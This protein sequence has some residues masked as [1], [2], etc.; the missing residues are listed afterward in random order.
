MN[1]VI[2]LLLIIAASFGSGA[3][4]LRLT[5]TYLSFSYLERLVISFI[6]GI[7]VIGWSVFYLALTGYLSPNN[8][9]V[10]LIGLS[11]GVIFLRSPPLT[12]LPFKAPDLV[13]MVLIG[14]IALIAAYD[15]FEGLAPPADGDSLAYHFAL[16]KLFLN[17]GELVPV[18][19]AV[20]GAIPLLQQ[21]T[22]LAALG[23]GGEQ[24][25]TLWVMVT[26]W[27]AAFTVY[28]VARRFVGNN[29]SLAI[30]LIFL[31]T[32]AVVYGAGSGQVEVRN[33]SFV[34]I[35]A[36]AIGLARK[37][38]LLRFALLAGLAAGF[39]VA[40]KYTGL[41][42]AASAGTLLLFKKDWFRHCIVFSAAVLVAGSQWYGW[43]TW[44]TGDPVFPLL[45]GRL[46]YLP[47][48]P[49]NELIHEIYNDG[50][51]EKSISTD[52]FWF[53]FYPFKATLYPDPSFESLRTGFGPLVLLVLPLS[54]YGLWHFRDRLQG[55]ILATIGAICLISY[56]VWFFLGPS[57]R[58]RHLLPL[59]PIL[60]ICIS[61]AAIR[62]IQ[63]K[64]D[65]RFAL[66]GAFAITILI[67][68]TGATVFA[69]NYVRYSLLG[70]G[71]SSFLNRTVSQFK[72]VPDINKRLDQND[73]LLVSIRQLVYH[74]TVPVFYANPFT[75]VEVELHAK[76][77]DP[78]IL[79]RQLKQ[80]KISH[81]LVQMRFGESN[82]TYGYDR[83]V[84]QLRRKK[85]LKL[86]EEYSVT[87]LRS[88]TIRGLGEYETQFSLVE[89]TPGSCQY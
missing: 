11:C 30:A 73:R 12:A 29:W 59:Y 75:Q 19:Q 10:C 80:Q 18:Y 49:W 44:N 48:V 45:Y 51:G 35:A 23:I 7:G 14:A 62:L 4:L 5:S 86:E 83:M 87:A 17:S 60:L 82:Y 58:I 36:L 21:M 89:L 76:A 34:L 54:L 6:L 33:S 25:M 74:F 27:G 81:M 77:T 15:L 71:R 13:G 53:I 65:F 28:I 72:I 8:L 38:N 39:F 47:T 85:C 55:H 70:E 9:I 52:L 37:E 22:Y 63:A 32:P 84:D 78:K 69:S 56:S 57:L 46:E 64:T 88:R 1:T 41:V 79:W 24:A 40:S 50:I 16:P 67:H 2:S 31:S 26:G 66:I 42:F 61:V 3:L 43:N 20:E 68:F